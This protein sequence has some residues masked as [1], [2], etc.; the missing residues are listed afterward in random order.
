MF[1]K[2]ICS[3]VV[4]AT[5]CSGS[6]MATADNNYIDHIKE[7]YYVDLPSQY[8]LNS[9]KYAIN[10]TS[11]SERF[12]VNIDISTLDGQ[13][14]FLEKLKSG[15]ISDIAEPENLYNALC[16]HPMGAGT[17]ILNSDGSIK[18]VYV[19]DS[20]DLYSLQFSNKLFLKELEDSALNLNNTYAKFIGIPMYAEGIIFSDG[21]VEYFL[22]KV[23]RESSLEV[24]HLY[25]IDEVIGDI[26]L[27]SQNLLYEPVECKIVNG[28]AD[29]A[30]GSAGKISV[31]SAHNQVNS[32]LVVSIT[33]SIFSLA[34]LFY[35]IR[36]IKYCS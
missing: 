29:P 13:K 15:K 20:G 35:S 17:A 19:A 9:S 7:S 31:Y 27:N 8:E 26:E 1:K 36:K 33:G 4:F 22:P 25:S 6:L 5:I 28:I 21:N 30:M 18:Q 10:S 24:G 16:E 34:I 2:L 23:L 11:I 3:A 12:N 14:E 32:L